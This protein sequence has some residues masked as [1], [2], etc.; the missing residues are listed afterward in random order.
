VSL[1][2][3]AL[4]SRRVGRLVLEQIGGFELVVL[5]DVFNPTVFRTSPVL[6]DAVNAHVRAGMRVLDLGTGTGVAAIA[7]AAAGASVVAVDINPEAARSARINALLNHVDASVE[8]REGDLFAPVAG[9]RF[10]AVVCNPPF[11]SGRP[12]T[13]RDAAWRSEDFIERFCAGLDDVL[14]GAGFAL[15]V[16]SNHADED[17][18]LAELAASGWRSVIDRRRRLRGEVVTVYRVARGDR[19]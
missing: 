4:L 12:T 19:R 6:L 13:A 14:D 17:G 15:I 7:A 11:F 9:I 2:Q 16:F 18:L 3:R 1:L 10:D 8:V 5:P